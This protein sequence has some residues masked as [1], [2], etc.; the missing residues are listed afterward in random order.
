MLFDVAGFQLL[1]TGAIMY[2]G[3]D[4]YRNDYYFRIWGQFVPDSYASS[5]L[6]LKIDPLHPLYVHSFWATW[7]ISGV[8]APF[9]PYNQ[10][11]ATFTHQITNNSDP[12]WFDIMMSRVPDPTF[13]V[14]GQYI[15][16]SQTSNPTE[17]IFSDSFYWLVLTNIIYLVG[18]IALALQTYRFRLKFSTWLWEIHDLIAIAFLSSCHHAAKI[19]I[20][21]TDFISDEMHNSFSFMDD[22]FSLLLLTSIVT[23]H[24]ETNPKI[25]RW[26]HITYQTVVKL[27]TLVLVSFYSV[28]YQWMKSTLPVIIINGLA[29]VY[30]VVDS[31]RQSRLKDQKLRL[32]FLTLGAFFIIAARVLKSTRGSYVL[33]HS[34]WHFLSGLAILC[35]IGGIA[36]P[37][38]SITSPV[39]IFSA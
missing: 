39:P 34:L 25:P 6:S 31:I 22:L 19:L 26:A 17:F 10:E 38:K 1:C 8:R 33:Y 3:I 12:I 30:C 14:N 36:V 11:T 32:V 15:S 5:Q 4:N 18:A 9:V 23:M 29:L 16:R 20:Y 2:F 37:I 13:I 24:F 35:N 28:E 7:D 21:K 27:I